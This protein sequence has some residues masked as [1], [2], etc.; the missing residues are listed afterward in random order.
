MS[1]ILR[2]FLSG[3]REPIMTPILTKFLKDGG[4]EPISTPILRKISKGRRGRTYRELCNCTRK[5]S[6]PSI[7]IRA[8]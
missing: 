3:W 2:K 4:H 6:N 8:T 7:P 5:A 1:L